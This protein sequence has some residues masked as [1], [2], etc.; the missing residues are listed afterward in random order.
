VYWLMSN[1]VDRFRAWVGTFFMPPALTSLIDFLFQKKDFYVWPY[2]NT[3][4]TILSSERCHALLRLPCSGGRRVW[5]PRSRWPPTTASA[6]RPTSR[7]ARR[8]ALN[9]T[10]NRRVDWLPNWSIFF[11]LFI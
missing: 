2:F 3:C 10:M 9:A 1:T 5:T 4:H 6:A 8:G 11:S 7:A